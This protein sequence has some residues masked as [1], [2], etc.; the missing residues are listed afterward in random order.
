MAEP[1]FD[2]EDKI[3]LVMEWHKI[4][5]E[6]AINA[7]IESSWSDA[8]AIFELYRRF[9]NQNNQNFLKANIIR[10]TNKFLVRTNGF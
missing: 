5:R 9:H 4:N 10:F 2:R 6:V 8:D 7:L 1:S 3:R